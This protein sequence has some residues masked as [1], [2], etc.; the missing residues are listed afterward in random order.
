MTHP[1]VENDPF[2]KA[3]TDEPSYFAGKIST[4]AWVCVLEKGVG[5]VPFDPQIHQGL[6]TSTV[7]EFTI[8]PLDPTR[9]LIQ[10]DCLNWT[11]D[12]KSVI[13]PSLELIAEKIGQIRNVQPG[14]FNPL[15]EINGLYVTGEFVPRPDNKPG[16]TWTTLKIMD[17]FETEA[18]CQAS[19]DELLDLEPAPV[20]AVQDADPQ[21]AAM[22]AFLPALWKQAGESTAEFL[23]LIQQNPMLA[24]KFDANSPEVKALTINEVPF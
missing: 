5:K 24:D 4:D 3:M 11:P 2:D 13:R 17:V 14:Q 8:E 23:L 1:H 12:F 9:Q 15:R 21:R 7:I 20:A 19:H 6:R 22:A 10:R 16:D 18:E